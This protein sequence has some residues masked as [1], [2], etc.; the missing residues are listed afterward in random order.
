MTPPDAPDPLAPRAAATPAAD[1]SA[2]PAPAATS[3]IARWILPGALLAGFLTL[4]VL[5]TLQGLKPTAA[6][7]EQEIA[8]LLLDPAT[9]RWVL[10]DAKDPARRPFASVVGDTPGRR[11]FFAT[12]RLPPPGTGRTYV[13]WTVGREP[14]AAPRNVGSVAVKS[15]AKVVLEMSE[16]PSLRDLSAF[17]VSAESDPKA[18]A[19]TDVVA[20]G[21]A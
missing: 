2:S 10:L 18:A 13:L 12:N 9:P 1:G 7:A 21:G 5:N 3:R 16:A 17:L 15:E 14:N 6:A 19:P 8:A 11:L 4:A 20:S